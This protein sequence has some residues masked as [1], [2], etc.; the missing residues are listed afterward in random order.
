MGPIV[1]MQDVSLRY[2]SLSGETPA[3]SH[4]TFNV[5]PGEFISDVGPSGCGKSTILS[6][7]AGQLTPSEGSISINGRIGYMLQKDYLLHWR[8]IRSNA[9]L[10]LEI[11]KNLTPENT[12]Y[13][14]ELLDQYGLGEFK[15][16][17]PS[18]L[19]GGMR[20]RVALIR[21][22][23]VR[24]DIL[25]LDEP[26]SALDYQTRLSV[27]DEIGTI[28]RKEKKTAILVT[29]DISEAIS[30]SDR[31]IVLTKRPATVKCIFSIH[32]SIDEYSPMKAREAPEFKEY[33][34]AIWK[35]LDVHV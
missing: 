14:E 1:S 8:T 20:Q 11:Q 15:E 30:L 29:H 17:T 31:V 18:Q 16:H 27:S 3:V 22:L 5:E 32:L 12:A 24:P 35:E 4:L 33:F 25:L 7:L 19:S 13:I 2:H 9:S 21:T 23:A 28:I 10:G 34:N 6:M 26:F